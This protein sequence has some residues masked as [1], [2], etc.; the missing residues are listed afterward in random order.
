[1]KTAVF[2]GAGAS[3][4]EGAPI[5][6]NLFRDYFEAT[7]FAS[8]N[9]NSEMNHELGDFFRY[10]FGVD[11]RFVNPRDVTFPTFEE[12][13]GILDMAEK[14]KESFRGY[15][16]DTITHK[17]DKIRIIHQY[18]V[19]LMAKSIHDNLETYNG[20]HNEL[21]NKLK[22]K[23]Q[24]KDTVFVST[25]YD[26]LIDNAIASHYP[27]ITIDY[28]L[29]FTNYKNQGDWAPPDNNAVK[30]Y[31]MHGSLNWLYCTTC[32]NLKLTPREKG[33]LRLISNVE[34]ATCSYC[35]SIVSPIIVPPTY[36]K[37]MSNVFL[38]T[39][40]YNIEKELREIDHIIFCGY[41]FPDSDMHLKYL[42]KRI[43]TNRNGSL[44]ISVMNHHPGKSVKV[45]REE[46]ER[47]KRFFRSEVLYRKKGF[48]EFSNNPLYYFRN[49]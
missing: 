48:R 1:M 24:I 29:D 7:S 9:N 4:A 19:L 18:L 43:E 6:S 13:L 42:L 16:L 12:A 37:N 36:F 27:D 31:K 46:E 20:Y 39:I 33:I 22:L 34:N 44:K 25:N 17:K 49:S 40:W 10:F 41:S 23:S 3:A 45:R 30:L 21:I 14:R 2:L 47:F 26:I 15:N 28:G 32:N 8:N 11:L 38:N 5:Q 35:N